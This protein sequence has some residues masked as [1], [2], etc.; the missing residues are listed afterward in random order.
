MPGT[1]WWRWKTAP[2]VLA[3]YSY[4][5]LNRRVTETAGGQ[6]TAFYFAS[7][8]LRSRGSGE[9]DQVIESA[10]CPLSLW[11]RA[12][13]RAA[14]DHC[15][16]LCR[17]PANVQYVW[18]LRNVDDLVLRDSNNG[19]GGNLGINGSGL[20]LRLYALQDANWNVV[21]VGRRRAARCKSGSRTRPTGPPRP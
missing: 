3:T 12:R 10:F 18:G 16:D 6:T 2:T 8:P 4:D 15:L 19:T 11:E 1:A 9:G 5:G 7:L 13:V 14:S 20:G 17:L 21:A